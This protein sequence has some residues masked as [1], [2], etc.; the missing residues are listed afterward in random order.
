MTLIALAAA[1]SSCEGS[2]GG[3]EG[4]VGGSCGGSS[5]GLANGGATIGGMASSG[6]ASS[7]GLT[8]GGA[9]TGGIAGA[10]GAPS[11]GRS[12]GGNA[13]SGGLA[14]GGADTGGNGGGPSG[15]LATGGAD[16][17]GSGHTPSGGAATG[18]LGGA[19]MGGVAGSGG[20]LGGGTGG[21]T[22]GG[23]T[24]ACAVNCASSPVGSCSAPEVRIKDVDVGVAVLSNEAET[25]LEPLSIAPIPSGGSRLAWMSDD[26]RVHIAQLDCN[27]ELVGAPFSF[28]AHDFQDVAADDGGGVV[29]LTRDALGGGTLNCGTPGNLCDGGPNP[30]VPCHDM[31]MVRF[32]CAGNA[33]WTTLLT[34]ATA[35]LPPY[36]TG[37]GGPTVNMI[38]WY[39]HHGRLA[40]DGSN[41]AAYF[42]NAISISEG[43]C[44][45]IHE[46]DRMQV[47][48]P[49]GSILSHP[50]SFG[51]GCSHSW[52]TRMV[53]DDATDHFVMVCATD[54]IGRVARPNP[55]RTIWT[56]RD[57]GSL[58]VGDLVV[59]SGGGYWVSMSDEG[60]VHLLH[61]T[62][63]TPDQDV[64]AASSD[65]SHLARYGTDH[66]L[67]GWES[68]GG[69]AAQVRSA[70]DGSVV[71]PE[72]SVAVPNN[73]YASFETYPDG[74]V[75][76]AAPGTTNTSI[77]VARV[78][79]CSP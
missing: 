25:T 76:Y 40:W 71:S 53:W 58:S 67:V 50:D 13:G 7:G 4:C 14:T 52:N 36:S 19:A 75:A 61:F 23:S 30:A 11:G 44:I 1:T 73:R 31:W 24:T 45:N 62:E 12:T 46:G 2:G 26:D 77:R 37:P 70:T 72:F 38:W 32:D 20:A 74:S 42:C 78:M 66:L 43:G 69:I 51:G 48:G 59:A 33:E 35:S 79:P 41:Y 3:D 8:N 68:G 49:D 6:G 15:G 5:G 47:V 21:A 28:P 65:F 29:V 63:S 10:S 22:T 18:G 9:P 56:A 64:I 57:L 39:Q 17:G 34:T 54:N 16:T 27:D 60:S 55:Y